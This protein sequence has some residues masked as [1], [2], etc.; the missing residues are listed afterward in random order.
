MNPDQTGR[1]GARGRIFAAAVLGMAVA[2][3]PLAGDNINFAPSS[4]NVDQSVAFTYIALNPLA[5]PLRWEFGDGATFISAAG[6]LTARHTYSA[7]G[8]Y[9]I[10]ARLQSAGVPSPLVTVSI[11]VVERR[12]VTFSPPNPVPGTPVTFTAN[13]FFSEN[14]VWNFGE[15]S[16]L[17]G[18][19]T[20]IHTYRNGGTYAVQAWDLNGRSG[21]SVKTQVVV[22]GVPSIAVFPPDVRTNVPVEFRAVNF[23]STTLIRWDFGDG[24]V[25]NDADPPA[26]SHTYRTAGVF[27]VRAFDNGGAAQTAAVS[28]RVLSERM[29]T[30]NPADPRVGEEAVFQA[31]N[32]TSSSLRWDFGDGAILDPAGVRVGHVYSSTG[33]FTVRAFELSGGAQVMAALPL[34][35]YPAL[36]P[37]AAFALSYVHLRFE[38]GKAYRTIPRNYDRLAA[39]A[40]IKYEGTG[41]MQAQWLVDGLPFK[42][43]LMPLAFAG[44]TVIDSGRLPGLPSVVPG[45]HEVTLNIIMPRSDFSVPVIRYFVTADPGAAGPVELALRGAEDLDGAVLKSGPDEI[46]APAGGPFLVRGVIRN[47][48][49]D[50]VPFGLLRVFLD[51]QIT[52]QKLVRD[53]RPGE[54]RAFESSIPYPAAERKRLVFVLYDISRKPVPILYYR[55][56]TVVP[57][58]G[59]QRIR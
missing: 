29:I 20:E 8:T 47:E 40:E 37:R 44:S 14:I 59:N 7:A 48:G 34:S 17:Q 13:N 23:A 18:Q 50:S 25:A 4:P 9:L 3:L 30:M 11:A 27:M 43:A 57:A 33:P 31:L 56:M 49:A 19:R 16:S 1:R 36:G 53:L 45:I 46:A 52:D 21:T 58:E 22:G 12:T 26:I 54:E 24:T 42:T 6:V 28:V 5:V 39:Y 35:V 38:D 32:F 55:E 51:E 41:T 2:A 15:G 10:R